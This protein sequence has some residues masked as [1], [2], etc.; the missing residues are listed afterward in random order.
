MKSFF[1]IDDYRLL[2]THYYKGMPKRYKYQNG[3]VE[4]LVWYS[5]RDWKYF[6]RRIAYLREESEIEKQMLKDLI[7]IG[8]KAVDILRNS[9]KFD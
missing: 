6:V 3:H 7:P 1:D 2:A 9:V 8:I 4:L 5:G